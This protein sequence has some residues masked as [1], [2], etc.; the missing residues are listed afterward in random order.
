[1]NSWIGFK[2]LFD[3]FPEA[4]AQVFGGNIDLINPFGG[5]DWV[6]VTNN[7]V[8]GLGTVSVAIMTIMVL[9]GGFQIITAG[10]D[11]EKFQT[12]KRTILYA[13]IG[14][15]VL[16]VAGSVANIIKSIFS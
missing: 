1:M 7:I 3:F 13:A 4:S 8:N 16:L 11:P 12:G 6:C 5:C 9:Y 10:G 15:V 2:N 14:F